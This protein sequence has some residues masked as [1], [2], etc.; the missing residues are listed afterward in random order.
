MSKSMRVHS[1]FGRGLCAGAAALLVTVAGGAAGQAELAA[2]S[3]P[4]SAESGVTRLLGEPRPGID[5]PAVVMSPLSVSTRPTTSDFATALDADLD[6]AMA[7]GGLETVHLVGLPLS[8]G[9]LIDLDLERV[10]VTDPDAVIIHG[11]QQAARRGDEPLNV[12]F[13]GEVAG[14]PD[15]WAYVSFSRYG[16]RGIVEIAGETHI[17]SSGK[18]GLPAGSVVEPVVYNLTHLPEGEISWVEFACSV[19]DTPAVEG[20]GDG[21]VAAR[22][23]EEEPDPCRV[24]DV[25]IETDAEFG[26]LFT[27]SGNDG[28]AAQEAHNAY[29]ESLVGANNVI[30]GR[31]V[32]V[33]LNIVAVRSWVG[34]EQGDDP[35]EGTSTFSRLLE[36]RA[37]WTPTSTP[38]AVDE[39]QSV[40]MFSGARL[41]GGIAYLSAICNPNFSHAVSADLSGFFPTTEV[42]PDVFEPISNRSQNWDVVVT[43]HEWGHNFG[44]PHTHGLTPIFDGCGLGDC[45][46]AENGTIM[47]YCQLCPGGVANI[48]LNF[49]DR[50]L[51]EGIRPYLNFEA[52]CDLEEVDAECDTPIAEEE[53]CL[54]DV[55]EDGVLSFS[56]FIAW[57]VYFNQ[58]DLRADI[59]VDGQITG[60]DFNAWLVAFNLGCEGYD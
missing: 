27:G 4:R 36:L 55:N 20:E 5:V 57:L 24:V 12:M 44:A 13:S 45:S 6:A 35:W 37:A 30:Y 41:G 9:E 7:L 60:G 53:R 50:I 31:N 22:G 33:R 17:I 54:A 1:G 18:L 26:G 10:R 29:V 8:A 25:V 40:H 59:N 28:L 32:N 49:A 11:D 21:P 42:S 47:S 34:A 58:G 16:V 56:D 3:H 48:E 38:I 23:S 14:E 19:I 15:S 52:R 51:N 46:D 39:W 2:S 43:A